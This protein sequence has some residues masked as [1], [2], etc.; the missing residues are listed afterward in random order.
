MEKLRNKFLQLLNV[1]RFHRKRYL[2]HDINWKDRFIIIKG[3]RGVGKTT[4]LLQYI[5]SELINLDTTLFISLDDIYFTSHRLSD[6]AETFIQNGG[7]HLFIDEIHRYPD[8]SIE[9]KNLYD[10]YPNLKIIA[11]GSSAIA[12]DNKKSDLSRRASVYHLPTLSL[13]EYLFLSDIAEFERFTLKDIVTKHQ[14]IAIAINQ[15]IKPI[16]QFNHFTNH[17]AYPFIQKD[18]PLF[19]DKLTHVVNTIIENDM[20]AIE[21]INYETQ[22]KIKKLLYVISKSVPFKP[23]ISELSKK[24]GTSRDV[25]LNYLHLLSASGIINLLKQSG[26]PGSILQKPEKIYINN[27]TLLLALNENANKGTLR[28]TFFMNQV[29]G[30]HE[31]TASKKGDFFVDNHY[32]FEVGGKNKSKKQIAGID[33]SYTVVSD[34]EYGINNKIPIFLFGFL[35]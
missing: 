26:S 23:N 1:T 21:N 30:M 34:I 31:I 27:T 24:I 16:E 35:Y 6:L 28:E 32:T 3:Q 19:R 22:I 11:T 29:M 9:L 2:Y 20:P 8:W 7:T 10:F 17:G 25:L 5:Q 4:M 18:D 13:R 14:Q 33:Q 12:I 15:K